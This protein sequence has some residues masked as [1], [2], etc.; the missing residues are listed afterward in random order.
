MSDD[1]ARFKIHSLDQA[2]AVHATRK[3]AA[4]KPQDLVA[5]LRAQGIGTIEDLAKVIVSHAAGAVRGNAYD[6]EY[7]PVCYKFTTARPHFGDISREELQG[8]VREIEA[9]GVG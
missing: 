3:L 6:A 5:E 1:K 7:F 8:L 4:T 2:V 9:G